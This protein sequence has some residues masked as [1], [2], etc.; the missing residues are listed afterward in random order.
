MSSTYAPLSLFLRTVVECMFPLDICKSIIDKKFT[1]ICNILLALIYLV[2]D[3]VL[4]FIVLLMVD[5]FASTNPTDPKKQSDTQ[6]TST[7]DVFG[8]VPNVFADM[9]A[10][11]FQPIDPETG[12]PT[13]HTAETLDPFLRDDLSDISPDTQAKPL[14]SEPSPDAVDAFG[15]KTEQSS[16]N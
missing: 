6:D 9:A 16:D 12:K 5:P 4:Y 1:K 14:E 3:I 11:A 8:G 15:I 10:T 13:E 2:V 7:Q